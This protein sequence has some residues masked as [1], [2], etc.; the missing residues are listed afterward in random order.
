MRSPRYTRSLSRRERQVLIRVAEGRT[1]AEVA[2]AMKLSP[3]TI[4]SH[5]ARIME[6]VGAK[7]R[8]EACRKVFGWEIP[9]D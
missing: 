9:K 8:L 6:R 3:K 5:L 1:N 7:S 4:E 2:A